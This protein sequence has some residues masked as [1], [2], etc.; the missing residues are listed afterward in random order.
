MHNQCILYRGDVKI[1]YH[2]VRITLFIS[3]SSDITIVYDCL[4]TVAPL[5]WLC[6]H[7]IVEIANMVNNTVITKLFTILSKL[8]TL[9][10]ILLQCVDHIVSNLGEVCCWLWCI[11]F[12]V[13][14]YANLVSWH[15]NLG[16]KRVQ[17]LTL[18]MLAKPN[19]VSLGN[20]YY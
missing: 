5:P 4:I 8:A 11:F 14:W 13:P 18:P 10:T 2:I 20:V 19:M 15:C 17:L 3:H 1:P 9:L 6:H 12:L 7:N 16:Y